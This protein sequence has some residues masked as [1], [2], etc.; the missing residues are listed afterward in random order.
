MRVADQDPNYDA[1]TICIMAYIAC[2]KLLSDGGVDTRLV[3][4]PT[5]GRTCDS[6]MILAF[7][8]LRDREKRIGRAAY[9]VDL[10]KSQ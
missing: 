7:F 6:E 3:D 4:R 10:D 8:R 2:S 5:Q 1:K 9:D